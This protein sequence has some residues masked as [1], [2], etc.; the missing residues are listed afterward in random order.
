MMSIPKR[1]DLSFL[2]ILTS[3]LHIV[4]LPSNQTAVVIQKTTPMA[5]DRALDSTEDSEPSLSQ[6]QDR[7]D[8][9]WEKQLHL[10]DQYD[11]AQRQLQGHISSV[12]EHFK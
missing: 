1:Q 4:Y 3:E 7:L 12:R 10:L 6:M 9:L 2:R 11:Q 8:A 5:T